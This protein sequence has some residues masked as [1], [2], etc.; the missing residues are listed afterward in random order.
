MSSEGFEWSSS[1][2]SGEEN[3]GRRS[4]LE[5]VEASTAFMDTR[6]FKGYAT[7]VELLSKD[8]SMIHLCFKALEDVA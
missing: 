7:L 5:D 8:V 4:S 1:M 3:R 6:P 2:E